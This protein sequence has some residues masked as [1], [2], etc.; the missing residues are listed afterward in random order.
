ML[1]ATK[2]VVNGIDVVFTALAGGRTKAVDPRRLY[3][4]DRVNGSHANGPKL[5]TPK[6]RSATPR[7]V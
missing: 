4:G 6:K 5:F 3:R 1:T 2:D 7:R